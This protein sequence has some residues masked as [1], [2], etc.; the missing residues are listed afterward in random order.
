MYQIFS[1]NCLSGVISH[2]NF[3]HGIQNC[4][5]LIKKFIKIEFEN[6][7]KS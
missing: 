3:L 4:D 7:F 6:Q 2:A 5:F 1:L